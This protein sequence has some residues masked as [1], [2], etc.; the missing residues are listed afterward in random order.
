MR[1][2]ANREPK[3]GKK[4][5]EHTG[6]N[7]NQST[8]PLLIMYLHIEIGIVTAFYG[9]RYIKRFPTQDQSLVIDE[10]DYE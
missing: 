5:R 2:W 9:L 6:K 7:V 10:F 8:C 4:F 1:V 3:G